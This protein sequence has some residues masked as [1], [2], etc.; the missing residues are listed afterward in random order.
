MNI[1]W[2]MR[3]SNWARNPPPLSRVILIAA[4]VVI[5]LLLY[6]AEQIWGWPDWM[7]ER[8]PRRPF[9]P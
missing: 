1:R 4:V 7:P 5:C 2:L 3:A 9:R 8:A 6:G